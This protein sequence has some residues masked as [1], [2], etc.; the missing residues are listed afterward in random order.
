M[1]DEEAPVLHASVP[2]ALVE[3]TE[4]PQLLTTVIAGV[5]GVAFGAAV[6]VAAGLIH[7]FTDCV[8]VYE[9]AVFTVM[10]DEV[11]PVLHTRLLPVAVSVEV[12]SQLSATATTGAAGVLACTVTVKLYVLAASPLVAVQVMVV[13]P[14]FRVIPARLLPL[15]V[16]APESVYVRTGIP[17]ASAGVTVALSSAPSTV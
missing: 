4:F 1:D 14:V 6:T 10:D 8:T 11:A 16:V 13:L 3:S 7:P 9:P 12:L 2:D 5:A 17:H 15:P